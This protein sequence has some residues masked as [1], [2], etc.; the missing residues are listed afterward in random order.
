MRQKPGQLF[1]SLLAGALLGGAIGSEGPRD[2]NGKR[3]PSP[4]GF[5]S[6]VARGG[7]AVEQQNYQRR[8]EGQENAR[9]QAQLTLEQQRVQDEHMLHQATV[10]HLTAET[11]SFHHQQEFH[12]QE[13]LD[14][15]NK[16][17]QQY[18]QALRDAGGRTAPIPVNGKVPA[19]GEYSAPDIAAA[20][21]KDQSILH[22]PA[23]TVRHFVDVHNASDLEY[24]PGTGWVNEAGDPVDMSKSTVVRAIDV[25]ENQFGKPVRKTGQELNT[26]AGYQLIPKEQED[27]TFNVPINAV[28]GL[29]TQNLKNLNEQAQ[30]K[31][32]L[33]AAGKAVAA[34]AAKR[35]TPAQFAQVES[36][37]AAALAKAE[38]AY[39]K[40]DLDADE[41]AQAKAAA[42]KTYQDEIKALNGSGQTKPRGAKA[43]SG[44][45]A[46][47]TM[48][49]PGS[50]GKLHWSDGQKDL[51]VVQ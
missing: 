36:K 20:Y 15:K 41:L 12:D 17:A 24:V 50:D 47:A 37:K 25:P 40:G 9:K 32:R 48:Q 16:A 38:T 51:G 27:N 21:M 7:N 28:T 3:L 46:G 45:P 31:Q 30:T 29:Y 4:G 18:T 39:Q 35:G 22:G 2:E 13:A 26:I 43:P 23:G 14:R 34:Q 19:N 42:Q 1:R 10:A 49:V 33:A 5:L 6:G 44:P 11:A 8:Q